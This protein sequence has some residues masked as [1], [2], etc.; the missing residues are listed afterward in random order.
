MPA[1]RRPPRRRGRPPKYGRPARVIAATLPQ[2]TIDA[3][4]GVHSDLGW[5]IVRV[6]DKAMRR[7][8]VRRAAADDVSLV[9]I[10]GGQAL[11]VVDPV[12]VRGLPGV[13]VV[14]LSDR[15]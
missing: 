8:P 1:G 9:Q 3:L 13:Q 7:T 14:P 6:V 10:G 4:A 11:I 15:Q 12:L 2:E 5:A